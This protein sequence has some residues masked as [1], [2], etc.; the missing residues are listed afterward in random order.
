MCDGKTTVAEMTERAAQSL[1][2][3]VDSTFVS[4]ALEQLRSDGLL[5]PGISLPLGA[6]AVTRAQVMR[7]MGR[8]GIAAAVAIPLVTAIMAPTAAK[9]YGRLE[10]DNPI[11]RD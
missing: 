5:E 1:G 7:R 8:A 10:T 3:P 11:R 6:T 9:A 2:T 4:F